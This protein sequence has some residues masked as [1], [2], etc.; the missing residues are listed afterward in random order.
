MQEELKSLKET[1]KKSGV[2]SVLDM[3]RQLASRPAP[4]VDPYALI[5]ALG[6]L[7]DV[8][9]ETGHAE[10]K[11][12]QAIFKQCRNMAREPR[13]ASIVIQLLGDQ[14]QRQIAGQIH[15][16]LKAS[17]RPA[18]Y[19]SDFRDD[20]GPTSSRRWAN[21]PTRGRRAQQMRQRCFLCKRF[22]HFARNC[23]NKQ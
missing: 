9:R 19:L 23:P 22:G 21:N 4:L 6:Q 20:G 8:A 2:E 16:L 17:P 14:E 11:R 12:Y 18:P 13:L 5:A 10:H 7:S 1:V 15:K 3:V